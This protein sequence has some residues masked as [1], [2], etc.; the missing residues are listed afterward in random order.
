MSWQWGSLNPSHHEADATSKNFQR[1]FIQLDTQL[2]QVKYTRSPRL[3]MAVLGKRKA[4]QP[5][6]S[7]EDANEIFRRHFEAQFRPVAEAAPTGA[8]TAGSDDEDLNDSDGQDEDSE[9]DSEWGG[10]SDDDANGVERSTTSRVF[11]AYEW[12]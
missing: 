11:N 5:S 7:E 8:A 9:E 4:P 2:D 3:T 12:C 6:I 10:L 1:P